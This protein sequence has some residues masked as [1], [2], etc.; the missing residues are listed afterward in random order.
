MK[1]REIPLPARRYMIYHMIISPGI[2]VWYALPAYM[3]LTGFSPLEIGF[4]FSII[5]AAAI[6]T[7]YL[8][9]KYFNS[10]PIK[11]GLIA[12]DF[13]DGV[14]MILYSLS[15]GLFAPLFL[16]LGRLVEKISMMMYHLYPAYEQIIYPEEK[17]EEV[18]S[19]HLRTAEISTAATYPIL[20]YLLGYVFPDERSYR[21][22]FL[23]C[24]L[25]SAFTIW[26]LVKM[27]PDAGKEERMKI[28][29]FSFKFDRHFA[30]FLI[31]DCLFFM[32]EGFI[33]GFIMI[34]YIIKVLN[35]TI[36]EVAVLEA[37]MSLCTITATFASEKLSGMK[38][39][40]ALFVSFLLL[41]LSSA[42]M[43]SKPPFWGVLLVYALYN[44]ADSFLFPFYRQWFYSMVPP[45]KTTELHAACDSLRNLYG[46]FSA[47][48]AGTLASISPVF[49]YG[50]ASA[51]F[52]ACGTAALFMKIER[53][54]A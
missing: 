54:I 19:W 51:F 17:R 40:Q 1:W 48:L 50:L 47:A 34:N 46:I 6:P 43:L 37:L 28:T 49:G 52:A 5:N 35:K 36:F 31:V 12:I 27:L 11:K 22:F 4:L 38:K 9:G 24:G 45:E 7:T 16:F 32:A 10:V 18:L 21:V 41:S 3:L 44:F 25:M 13:L 20:G 15:K 29:K 53:K 14:S 8:I 2:F 23:L 39:G 26:Y 30:S 33:P 42:L